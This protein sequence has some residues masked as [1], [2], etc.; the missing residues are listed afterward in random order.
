MENSAVG[1]GGKLI[2]AKRKIVN[3]AGYLK[4][5]SEEKRY[6]RIK[7]AGDQEGSHTAPG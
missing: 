7:R 3:N 2:F 6:L 1:K 4:K 5:R